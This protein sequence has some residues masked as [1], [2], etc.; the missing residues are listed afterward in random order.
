MGNPSARRIDLSA[1]SYVCD[2]HAAEGIRPGAHDQ[3]IF[4]LHQPGIGR[5]NA[6]TALIH[7]LSHQRNRA[8][9]IYQRF[10]VICNVEHHIDQFFAAV[11]LVDVDLIIILRVLQRRL[12]TTGHGG[13]QWLRIGQIS[14]IR[15]QRTAAEQDQRHQQRCQTYTVFHT[16]PPRKYYN[17]FFNC[18]I[19]SGNKQAGGAASNAMLQQISKQPPAHIPL[20]ALCLYRSKANGKE[21]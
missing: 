3:P 21:G 14:A 13:G 12:R 6:I 10:L 8:V 20:A 18:N 16:L 9:L 7:H 2:M 1:L 17:R 4:T 5:E 11:G 15:R 19:H